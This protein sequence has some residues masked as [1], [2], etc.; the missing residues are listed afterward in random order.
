VIAD[1]G[2]LIALA[3]IGQLDL[4]R[5]VFGAVSLTSAVAA[6]I[7]IDARGAASR[8]GGM[9]S[10]NHWRE[11]GSPLPTLG[12]PLWPGGSQAPTTSLHRNC[13]RVGAGEG[14]ESDP[15]LRSAAARHAR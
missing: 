1:A 13:C 6:E 3:R 9:R 7:G 15:H 4:L 5:G 10:V 11:G 8:A 14:T 2:P 12:R